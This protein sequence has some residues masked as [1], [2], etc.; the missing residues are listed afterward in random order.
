MS[1]NIVKYF[2]TFHLPWSESVADDD[3]VRKSPFNSTDRVVVS[4]KLDG[5][6][7]VEGSTLIETEHGYKTIQ[8]I[9]DNKYSGKVKCYDVSTNNIMWENVTNWFI[10]NNNDNFFEIT[11]DDGSIVLLTE[12]HLVWCTN[13]KTYK[14]V[15][16]LTHDDD[17]LLIK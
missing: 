11:L 2:R 14:K 1:D 5:E 15:K 9:C 12:N 6:N 8:W 7:C 4:L 3:I 16:D 13:S 17:I 10:T